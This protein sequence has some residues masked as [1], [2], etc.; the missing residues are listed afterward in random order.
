[1]SKKILTLCFIHT[2][3]HVLLGMKKRG[4]GEGR[5]N[6]FGGKVM[7]EETIEDAAKRELWEEVGIT[8]HTVEKRGV[9]EFEFEKNPEILEVHVFKVLDYAGEPKESE[10]MK[11]QWFLRS[12]IPYHSMWPDD[13]IWLKHFLA[14]KRLTGHFLFGGGDA[15]LKHSLKILDA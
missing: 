9:L 3:T 6:G 12:E 4:F 1:M 14:G 5:W 11:P 8:A 15:I 10:E 2:D 7:P 13:S